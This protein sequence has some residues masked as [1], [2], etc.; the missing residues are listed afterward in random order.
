MIS[1]A[2]LGLSLMALGGLMMW[3]R[4][5]KQWQLW[6]AGASM[7]G[8]AVF[9]AVEMSRAELTSAELSV[10]EVSL[11][12]L[13]RAELRS[14][15]EPDTF[16]EKYARVNGVRCPVYERMNGTYYAL[17]DDSAVTVEWVDGYKRANGNPVNG[18]FRTPADAVAT[19]NFSADLH[20]SE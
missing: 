8:C 19:N 16:T 10:A 14:D 20:A 7:A 18:Y 12:E 4:W 9:S 3:A 2:T 17:L 6:A 11:A 1:G 5:H 15:D 13:S